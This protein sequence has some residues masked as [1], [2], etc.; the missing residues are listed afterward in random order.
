M[1]QNCNKKKRNNN[2][3][4]CLGFGGGRHVGE[5]EMSFIG[6]GFYAMWTQS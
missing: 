4:V 3:Y 2:I 1:E 5:F 6:E